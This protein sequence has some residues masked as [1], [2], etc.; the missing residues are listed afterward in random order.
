MRTPPQ[1]H[2]W[3]EGYNQWLSSGIGLDWRVSF[4]AGAT[5]PRTDYSLYEGWVCALHRQSNPNC[6]EAH[7]SSLPLQG[8][9]TPVGDPSL[10]SSTQWHAFGHCHKTPIGIFL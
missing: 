4:L 7:L 10:N 6:R 3:R 2:G 8:H 5:G 9:E 1:N